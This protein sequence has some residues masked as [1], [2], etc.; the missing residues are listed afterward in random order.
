[1]NSEGCALHINAKLI[2]K[3]IAGSR[4]PLLNYYVIENKFLAIDT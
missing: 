2:H 3:K 1:M 4:A